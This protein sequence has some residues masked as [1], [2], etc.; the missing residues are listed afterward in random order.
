M[1]PRRRAREIALQVLYSLDVNPALDV[2][3]ALAQY[4]DRFHGA[5]GDGDDTKPQEDDR[6]FAEELVREVSARRPRL[7]EWLREISHNWR[8]ERMAQVDRNILRMALY[9]LEHRDDI[10]GRVTINE[11]VELAKRYGAAEAP[12]FVNGML[13]SALRSLPAPK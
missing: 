12:A 9:E 2:P 7:D 6:V 10:P 3:A 13:D 1:I 5:D 4:F 11:A 8:L